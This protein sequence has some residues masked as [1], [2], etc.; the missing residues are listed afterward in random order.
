MGKKREKSI[1]DSTQE[2]NINNIPSLTKEFILKNRKEYLKG[3]D[4]ADS[5]RE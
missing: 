4:Y 5:E 3:L 2:K 1:K